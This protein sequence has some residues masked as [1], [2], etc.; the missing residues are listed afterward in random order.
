MRSRHFGDTLQVTRV[1]GVPAAAG[2]VHELWMIA[3]GAA[4]VSL[5]LLAG[6]PLVGHLP[7]PARGL[8]PRR[9]DRTRR[10][11]RPPGQ[12]TGPVILTAIVGS[13]PDH[14]SVSRKRR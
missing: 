2:Q 3:P 13:T 1:A 7:D 8:G 11:A 12:P 10:A 14:E 6:Q 9:L 5:G 4:P